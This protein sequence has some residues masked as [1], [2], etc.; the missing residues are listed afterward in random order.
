[1]YEDVDVER[2]REA[3][4]DRAVLFHERVLVTRRAGRVVV[5]LFTSLK[6]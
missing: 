1:M 4:E 3:A 5:Y 2:G 6:V